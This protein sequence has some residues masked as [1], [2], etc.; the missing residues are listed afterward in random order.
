[1]TGK[2]LAGVHASDLWAPPSWSG[3]GICCRGHRALMCG[4]KLAI[5]VLDASLFYGISP[6]C[7]AR[8]FKQMGVTADDDG[9][10]GAVDR[11]NALVML[12]PI[13]LIMEPVLDC[14]TPSAALR[15]GLAHCSGLPLLSTSAGL[16]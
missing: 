16:S 14:C 1:M 2:K 8:R 6:E 15:H 3:A 11:F 13:A 5:R 9:R 7:M 4:R 10:D 12:T